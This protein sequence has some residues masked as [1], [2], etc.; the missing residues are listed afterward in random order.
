MAKR[1]RADGTDDPTDTSDS[2][3]LTSEDVKPEENKEDHPNPQGLN[4]APGHDPDAPTA[5][6]LREKVPHYASTVTPAQPNVIPPTDRRVPPEN[7]TPAGSAPGTKTS[8]E[9]RHPDGSPVTPEQPA[10][11]AHIPTPHEVGL[12]RPELVAGRH[13]LPE[14]DPTP[15]LVPIPPPGPRRV[16]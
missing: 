12:P 7:V 4:L 8:G 9:A 2:S 11:A 10:E 14:E 5:G 6:P 13:P 16:A 15:S 1:K 3:T